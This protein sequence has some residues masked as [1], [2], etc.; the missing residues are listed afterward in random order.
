MKKKRGRLF[1]GL[2]STSGQ[3]SEKWG[4][5]KSYGGKVVHT[6]RHNAY[7]WEM[8]A[9]QFRESSPGRIPRIEFL[10]IEEYGRCESDKGLDKVLT[11]QQPTGSATTDNEWGSICV[12]KSHILRGVPLCVKISKMREIMYCTEGICDERTYSFRRGKA[13]LPGGRQGSNHTH[14]AIRSFSN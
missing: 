9:S 3:I 4:I 10:K 12:A 5:W 8:I 13:L 11:A 1:T 7:L 6:H 2:G 14:A